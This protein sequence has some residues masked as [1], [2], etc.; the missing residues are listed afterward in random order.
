MCFKVIF[1]YEAF[2]KGKNYK[3]EFLIKNPSDWFISPNSVTHKETTM[4]LFSYPTL[5]SP[6]SIC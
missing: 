3:R 2:S 5:P 6:L 1:G 4:F